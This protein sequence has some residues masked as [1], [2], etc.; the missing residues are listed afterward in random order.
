MGSKVSWPHCPRGLG[1]THGALSIQELVIRPW[2]VRTALRS[3]S[4]TW[5]LVSRGREL[6]GQ[7]LAE[8]AVGI[9]RQSGK[10]YCKALSSESPGRTVHSPRSHGPVRQIQRVLTL[11]CTDGTPDTGGASLHLRVPSTGKQA[12]CGEAEAWSE[13]GRGLRPRKNLRTLEF[14]SNGLMSLG[15]C[16]CV[17][18]CNPR[19]WREDSEAGLGYRVKLPSQPN[20]QTKAKG[21]RGR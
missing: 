15:L 8:E 3:L 1:R 14:I 12:G 2:V 5:E 17:H 13:T 7:M 4:W 19:A 10:P 16:L 20:K 21:K 9:F 6:Q 18:A 11:L